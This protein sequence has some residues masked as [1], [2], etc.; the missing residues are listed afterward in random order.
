M[1]WGNGFRPFAHIRGNH[2]GITSAKPAYPAQLFAKSAQKCSKRMPTN[3]AL[4][5]G[6]IVS[7]YSH[8]NRC[9]TREIGPYPRSQ[10]PAFEIGVRGD[11]SARH[12]TQIKEQSPDARM[13][14]SGPSQLLD[15]VEP[16]RCL[17]VFRREPLAE[18]KIAL[19]RVS[20]FFNLLVQLTAA[21]K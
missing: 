14:A 2:G 10:W 16:M 3:P 8:K 17:G 7:F 19:H 13:R 18:A 5:F 9:R 15:I 6:H 21:P 4:L 20:E 1:L 11:A 12:N